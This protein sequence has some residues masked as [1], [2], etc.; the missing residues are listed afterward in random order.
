[1]FDY[2]ERFCKRNR[3]HGSA[4]RMS[5]FKYETMN[6][7]QTVSSTAKATRNPLQRRTAVFQRCA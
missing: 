5:P 2:I 3:R 6:L 4:G 7:N 1:M